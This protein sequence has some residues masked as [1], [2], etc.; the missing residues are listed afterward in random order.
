MTEPS[1][2]ESSSIRS[3]LTWALLILALIGASALFIVRGPVYEVRSGLDFILLYSASRAWVHGENPYDDQAVKQ[4]WA[5]SGG[6]ADRGPG[7][8]EAPSLIYPPP[9]LLMM[10]PFGA[11]PWS[12]AQP[13]WIA[14]NIGFLAVSIWSL[15]RLAG[16]RIRQKR[17]WVFAIAALLFMPVHTTFRHGQTPLYVLCFLTLSAVW[18]RHVASGSLLAFATLLKPQIGLPFVCLDVVRWRL[19]SVIVAVALIAALSLLAIAPLAARSIDWRTS[20]SN[21]LVSFQHSGQ[22]DP[23]IA[24]PMRHQMLN[25]HVPLHSFFADR[26]LVS[27]MVLLV[28]ATLAGLFFRFWLWRFA[29]R[30]HDVLLAFSM[31]AVL[32]LMIVY[33]RFYDGVLLL[34]PLVWAIAAIARRA[35]NGGIVL[36]PAACVL[37]LMTPFF[38]N[39]A[40]VLWWLAFEQKLPASITDSWAWS[41]IAMPHQS[42]ALLLMAACLIW[43]QTRLANSGRTS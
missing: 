36:A 8:R 10:A 17:T 20:W 13:A 1:G 29:D 34:F 11:L 37:V 35:S 42:W 24:N 12:I 4:I 27:V 28:C 18:A 15:A 43:A 16:F 39:S 5:Q 22:G 31:V 19:R 25:L 30:D 9:T 6:P 23:T 7:S 14:A 40:T 38:T 41:A 26:M 3:R 21:N 32:T 2:P 33:H